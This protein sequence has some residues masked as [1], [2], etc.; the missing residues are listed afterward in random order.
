MFLLR[1]YFLFGNFFMSE[2]KF[3][4]KKISHQKKKFEQVFL[5]QVKI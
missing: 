1:I 3:S 5:S 2:K 4:P